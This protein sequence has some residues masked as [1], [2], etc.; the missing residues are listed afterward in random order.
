M[1]YKKNRTTSVEALHKAIPTQIQ[2]LQKE[3]DF[4]IQ[5][6]ASPLV[7]ALVGLAKK[8]LAFS[9]LSTKRRWDLTPRSMTRAPFATIKKRGN[10]E[11]RTI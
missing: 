11:P 2:P 4:L 9:Y 1:I 7:T 8:D 5:Y 6:P 3:P 10:Y